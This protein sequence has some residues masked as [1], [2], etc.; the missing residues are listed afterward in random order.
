MP[1]SRTTLARAGLVVAGL[2]I[3]V[4]LAE[5]LARAI[6]PDAAADLLFD[7][8]S[9]APAGMYMADEK[10]GWSPSPGFRGTLRSLGYSVPIAFN[11]LGHRGQEPTGTGGWLVLGDSFTLAAQVR[12]SDTF[13]AR[14]RSVGHT[15]HN[16]GADGYS[17]WHGRVRYQRAQQQLQ[18]DGVLLVY[19]LGNDP[20]DDERFSG[21]MHMLPGATHGEPLPALVGNPVEAF[22]AQRSYIY[23]Q[24]RVWMRRRALAAGSGDLHTTDKW[25][26]E[27]QAFTTSGQGKLQ[28][29]LN[30]GSR[31]ALR[32][33]RDDV[34]RGGGRLVV[35]LAP[36]AFVID[37]NRRAA[38]FSLVGLDPATA[39]VDAPAGLLTAE[40][41]HLGIANCDL[42][43]PLR[44]AHAAEPSEALYFTYDGH[45]TAA[46]HAVVADALAACIQ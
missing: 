9:N 4:L 15:T 27:L 35:A 30:R 16:A 29:V 20:G 26:A 5:V 42:T 17:T 10:L 45:W 22:F 40:L 18:P 3:G 19:F 7:A 37:A 25:R 41:R 12:E 39:D 32:E 28:Q 21:G 24:L 23:G 46:G 34:R 33:L 31:R 43:D 14:L 13:V 11:Q 44:A 38:T 8:P 1:P 36:P 2:L 6:A